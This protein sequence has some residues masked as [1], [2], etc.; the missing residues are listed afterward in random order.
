[1][2]SKLFIS[3]ILFGLLGG[4]LPLMLP[5]ARRKKAVPVVK[6]SKEE[7]IGRY[8]WFLA[9][10]AISAIVSLLVT[11]WFMDD[12]TAQRL[13]FNKMLFVQTVVGSMPML[14]LSAIQKH[15][16]DRFKTG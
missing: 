11:L 1:M 14:I 6:Y 12:V 9:R 4:F 8:G 16:L 5:L 13:S 15:V 10:L 7:Q 3:A 2:E